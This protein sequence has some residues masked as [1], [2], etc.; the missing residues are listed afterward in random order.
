MVNRPFPSGVLGWFCLHGAIHPIYRRDFLSVLPALVAFA[1]F[2]GWAHTIEILGA[3]IVL[4]QVSAQLFEPFLIGS[5][6]G[7]A[8]V[9]LLISAIYWAW[10]W[11]PIG[12][13]ISTPLAAC[14]KIAGDYIEPLNFLAL[15]LG[16]HTKGEDHQVYYGKLLELDYEGARS[17]ATKY[18][19]SARI[20]AHDQRSIIADARTCPYGAR[21]RS[22]Q[23]GGRDLCCH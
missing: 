6:V 4:D 13:L 22:H 17:F 9:A 11:G 2:P 18:L 12:L 1:I 16:A 21:A 5:G 7:V 23:S 15:L 10:L 14:L 20:R 8:P 19:R 3:Y